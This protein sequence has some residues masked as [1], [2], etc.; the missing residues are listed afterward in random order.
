MPHKVYIV[1]DDSA[2]RKA[3]TLLLSS[4]EFDVETFA[5]AKAFLEAYQ[6]PPPGIRCCLVSDVRMPGM[7]G[8]EL[9]EE[10]RRRQLAIPVVL[11][12]GHGGVP[13]AV[14]AMR[15]GAVSFLQKPFNEQEL[16]DLINLA[17]NRHA[18]DKPNNGHAEL[19]AKRALLSA[20]QREIFDLLIQGLQSKEVA[21]RLN[22][23]PRTIEVHRAHILV[24]LGAQSFAQ[25]IR[26]LLQRSI[27]S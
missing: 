11:M 9:Q 24:R 2:V 26:D 23:S 25:L 22:L 15:A 1:D 3:L 21:H 27:T 10:L 4:L 16:I 20:R 5:S 18:A 17:H 6:P 7:S 13:M 12:S 19:L 14:H 8:L